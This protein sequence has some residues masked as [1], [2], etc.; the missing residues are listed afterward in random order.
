M[1]WLASFPRSGNTFFRNILFEVYGLPSADYHPHKK[2]I[3][4]T[5]FPVI[6]THILPKHLPTHFQQK[7][8]VYLV[9]DGRD[10]L[11]SMAHSRSD[12]TSPFS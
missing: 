10:A 11:V 7:K 6:K 12:F 5:A 1:I 8:S 3:D 9:R 4:F 2:P